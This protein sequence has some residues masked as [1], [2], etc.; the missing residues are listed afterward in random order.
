MKNYL[1]KLKDQKIRDL[2]TAL[3][4]ALVIYNN[5]VSLA[6][7]N[8]FTPAEAI[9]P[10]NY[11]RILEFKTVKEAKY[12]EKYQEKLE[13]ANSRFKFGDIIRLRLNQHQKP[14]GQF[15]KEYQ[16]RLSSELFRIVQVI[17]SGGLFSYKL[18]ALDGSYRQPGTYTSEMMYSVVP[19]RNQE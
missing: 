1:S 10:A 2:K 13:R 7:D 4:E 14:S 11:Q 8:K 3:K 18:E 19:N 15:S 5:T 9:N 12:A 6:F 17:Q 16:F